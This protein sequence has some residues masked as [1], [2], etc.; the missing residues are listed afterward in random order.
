MSGAKGMSQELE[1]GSAAI[2]VELLSGVI[3]VRHTNENGII[4]FVGEVPAGTWDAIW[5]EIRKGVEA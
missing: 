5:Y 2:H 3:T 1:R 4:L